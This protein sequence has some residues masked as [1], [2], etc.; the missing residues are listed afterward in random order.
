MTKKHL[1]KVAKKEIAAWH[2]LPNGLVLAIL[3][4]YIEHVTNGEPIE[5]TFFKKQQHVP[6]Y[7]I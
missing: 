7:E 5:E 4:A 3:F 2:G 1:I 6:D